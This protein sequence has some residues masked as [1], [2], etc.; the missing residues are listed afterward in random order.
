[1]TSLGRSVSAV[2]ALLVPGASSPYPGRTGGVVSHRARRTAGSSSSQQ[3]A[4]AGCDE[5][6][7]GACTGGKQ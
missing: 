6:E 4:R 3:G 2:T 1:M 5:E 7:R